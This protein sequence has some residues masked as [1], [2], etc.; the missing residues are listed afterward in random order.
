MKCSMAATAHQSV[1]ASLRDL[2]ERA[3]RAVLPA[4]TELLIWFG[5]YCQRLI[6]RSGST[7]ELRQDLQG[8][9][10]CILHEL[11]AKYDTSRGIP[12]SAYLYANLRTGIY[13]RARR[14]WRH[15]EREPLGS[16]L[17]VDLGETQVARDTFSERVVLQECFLQALGQLTARQETV[18]Y[19]RFFE[20]REFEEIARMLGIRPVTVR[21]V[22]RNALHRL[23]AILLLEGVASDG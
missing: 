8:E 10:Y 18:M 12:L 20:E 2:D 9:V 5:P 14:E 4:P 17:D 23:R 7:P 16:S 3:A 11:V 22:Q 19:L 13:S 1:A 6:H 15:R 21:S